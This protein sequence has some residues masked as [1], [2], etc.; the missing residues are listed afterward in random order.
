MPVISAESLSNE[1]DWIALRIVEL[2]KESPK[3][4]DKA[5]QSVVATISLLNRLKLIDNCQAHA[6]NDQAHSV[7]EMANLGPNDKR[8]ATVPCDWKKE[9][10]N[11]Q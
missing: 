6:L 5:Y 7:L 3:D 4:R 9:S 11:E 8:H 10:G 2:P 1:L